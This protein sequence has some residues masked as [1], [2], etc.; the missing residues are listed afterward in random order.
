M[1]ANH[2]HARKDRQPH[3]H[4]VVRVAIFTLTVTLSCLGIDYLTRCSLAHATI[5][6]V[7][8]GSILSRF[9]EVLTDVICDRT[10]PHLFE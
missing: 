8:T 2:T 4:P 5:A 7:P 6:A 10:F 1:T 3:H 9:V